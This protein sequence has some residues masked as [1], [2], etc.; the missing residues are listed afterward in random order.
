MVC[1][2]VCVYSRHTTKH[3]RVCMCVCVASLTIPAG[4]SRASCRAATLPCVCFSP[5]SPLSSSS[6][7]VSLQGGK[8]HWRNERVQL[9]SHRCVLPVP[10]CLRRTEQWQLCVCVAFFSVSAGLLR[11]SCRAAT[12]PRLNFYPSSPDRCVDWSKHKWSILLFAL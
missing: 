7:V 11:T 8:W 5:S 10:V 12:L 2:C 6:N 1:V 9:N 3:W 4:L